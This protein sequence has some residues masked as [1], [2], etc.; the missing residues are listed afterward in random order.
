M[1]AA[2]ITG[3]NSIE[4]REFPEPEPVAG[5]AVVGVERY[6]GPGSGMRK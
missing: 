1:R 5:A 4:L 2:L 3:Q 6:M